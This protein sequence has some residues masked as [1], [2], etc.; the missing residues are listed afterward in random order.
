MNRNA[1]KEIMNTETWNCRSRSGNPTADEKATALRNICTMP[2]MCRSWRDSEQVLWSGMLYP[3]L[4]ELVGDYSCVEVSAKLAAMIGNDPLGREDD[5]YVSKQRI[6]TGGEV[7]TRS[8]ELFRSCSDT[9]SDVD[10]RSRVIGMSSYDGGIQTVWYER[11]SI[12]NF[13]GEAL[14]WCTVSETLLAKDAAR[15]RDSWLLMWLQENGILPDIVTSHPRGW[16]NA[17]L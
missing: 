13:Q 15:G 7:P 1:A 10:M 2:M 6:L 8:E 14:W 5:E 11:V 12:E 16:F 4:E 17:V 9:D 3:R